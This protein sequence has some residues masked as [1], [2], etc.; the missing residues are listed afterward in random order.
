MKKKNIFI[1][2]SVALL[3]FSACSEDTLDTI[4]KDNEHPAPDN[5]PAYLQLSEA[6]MN[7]GYSAVSGDYS[8]YISSLTEQ[9]IGVGNNQ[10]MKA[11]LRDPIEWAASTT[12]NNT[13]NSVYGN[14]NNIRQIISKI[15]NEVPGNIGQYDLLGIAQILEALNF[16]ILT[17]MHGD[18]PYSEAL[19]GLENLQPKLDSQ[20]D[21]Y[22]GILATLDSAIE[23]LDKGADLAS[24]QNQD[25][26]FNGDLNQW[27]AFAYSLKARYLLHKLAV[28]PEVL[29]D[30]KAA[31]QKAVELGFKGASI[32]E[33][34]GVT[35]DNPWYAFFMS[36][37]Y[38]LS[39]NTVANLMKANN[40]PRL[41][42]Y[43]YDLGEAYNPGDTEISQLTVLYNSS[44]GEPY[45]AFPE[46]LM[47]GS[48]PIH[49]FSESELYFILAETQLR[50]GEDATE[51]FQTAVKS[52]ISDIYSFFGEDGS[53]DAATFA[54][55]LGTPTLKTLFEQ[56]YV[57][58]C[59]DEQVETYND[60]RRLEAMGESYIN[61]TNPNNT[62]SGI[63]R[64]PYRLPY[65]N[66][67]VLGNPN[68]KE[69]YGDGYYIYSDKVWWA[70]GAN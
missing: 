15:E 40:D 33:F 14:L 18:I 27:K 45:Y 7:T 17:D 31:A 24:V 49:L 2:L 42:F 20:K 65:A 3:G 26:V 44:T 25:I 6:I 63:N 29:K 1:A 50:S 51:A 64:F 53:A 16:G 70:G 30:V 35:C 32:R 66:S 67:A 28:E 13:W 68:I 38:T 10:L 57:A 47:L 37:S 55:S 56:K 22:A 62:Q 19:K 69:A 60:L 61:L 5:V 46:W 48:Q 4:N 8:F 43:T 58:Q 54:E 41:G 12:F 34:N 23:N 11:E 36:R 59:V 9:E 52:S 21:V 39:S